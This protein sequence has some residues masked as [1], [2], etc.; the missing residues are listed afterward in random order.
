MTTYTKQQ[1]KKLWDSNE[2]G[3]G[4]TWDDIADCAV[5]WGLASKPKTMALEKVRSLVV[6]AAGSATVKVGK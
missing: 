5:A 4:I 6:A 1:F 2:R 3:G